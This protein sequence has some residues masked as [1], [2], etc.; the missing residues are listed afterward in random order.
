LLLLATVAAL[1]VPAL[2]TAGAEP[3]LLPGTRQLAFDIN[4]LSTQN[5]QPLLSM[6]DSVERAGERGDACSAAHHLGVLANFIGTK[7]GN[8]ITGEEARSL[9]S[10][11]EAVALGIVPPDPC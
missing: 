11:V 10:D 3:H 4:S 5:P 2:A 1:A 8:S 9:M 7:T 6:L